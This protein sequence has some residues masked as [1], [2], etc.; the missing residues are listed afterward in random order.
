MIALDGD[1]LQDALLA[2]DADVDHSDGQ[3]YGEVAEV[4]PGP[5]GATIPEPQGPLDEQRH[6]GED[7][8]TIRVSPSCFAMHIPQLTLKLPSSS[9]PTQ[10]LDLSPLQHCLPRRCRIGE[11]RLANGFHHHFS[12]FTETR[13]TQKSSHLAPDLKIS[14]SSTQE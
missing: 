10:L 4:L 14:M 13:T 12:R 11:Q 8:S 7:I 9:T 3:Q 6:D 1:V 2:N 5:G